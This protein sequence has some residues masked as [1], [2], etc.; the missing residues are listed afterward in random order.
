[1]QR[2]IPRNPAD[3]KVLDYYTNVGFCKYL[4][5]KKCIFLRIF[6]KPLENKE[7][8]ASIHVDAE[9]PKS[10]VTQ[11]NVCVIVKDNKNQCLGV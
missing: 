11:K 3:F 4:F 5:W 6:F 2:K 9:S 1:M 10:V 7:Q 8:R